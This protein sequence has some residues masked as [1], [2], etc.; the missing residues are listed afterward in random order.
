MKYLCILVKRVVC[1]MFVLEH[2]VDEFVASV[3]SVHCFVINDNV[4]KHFSI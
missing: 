2:F 1:G 4:P 3:I